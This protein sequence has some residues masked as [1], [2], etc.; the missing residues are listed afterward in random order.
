MEKRSLA[1]FSFCIDGHSESFPYFEEGLNGFIMLKIYLIG[2]ALIPWLVFPQMDHGNRLTFQVGV[3]VASINPPMG[4]FI[5]GG[6]QNRKFSGV[7]DNLFAK[8]VVVSNGDQKLALVTV[9]CIGLLKP[10]MDRIRKMAAA[11]CS[12]DP[13]RIVISSTHTHSGPDVVG[14]WGKDFTASGVDT[15]YLSF[16]VRSAASQIV[17]ANKKLMAV[18]GWVAEGVYQGKWVQNISDVELD[19]TL[20]VMQ[21]KSETGVPVVT[22][23]NFACH[24]T[25]LDE[26]FSVVSSDYPGVFYKSMQGTVGGEHMF[27]QGAIGGWVQPDGEKP[28]LEGMEKSGE[29]LAAATRT[30]LSTAKPL[31]DRNIFFADTTIQ[32]KVENQGWRMLSEAKV[33]GRTFTEAVETNM[34]W[35][36]IGGVQFATHPGETTPWLSL[37]TRK[38]MGVGPKMVMGLAQDALGYILKPEFFGKSTKAHAGYLTSMSLGKETTPAILGALKE[39]SKKAHATRSH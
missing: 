18:H 9:D 32:F 29:D 15:S 6:P 35:F 37:E 17:E 31:E 10:E 5:A 19:R 14:I 34:A 20:T 26:K 4:T 24:P 3:S 16:L 21:F 36:S 2:C 27:L 38:L 13:K 39:L 28:G 7:H 1:A 30:I 23:T 12:I 33:I 25:F 8:A 22:L 11:Q